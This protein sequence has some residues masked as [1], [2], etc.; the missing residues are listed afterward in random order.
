MTEPQRKMDSCREKWM[1]QPTARASMTAVTTTQQVRICSFVASR[2]LVAV[3]GLCLKA[4]FL[5]GRSW[6]SEAAA[7][8]SSL[9]CVAAARRP[10]ATAH[11]TC[12]CRPTQ[13]ATGR[14]RAPLCTRGMPAGKEGGETREQ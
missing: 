11:T 7:G 12:C 6:G 2:M 4:A 14:M 9:C 10:P 8:G 3:F 13:R 5:H 1:V